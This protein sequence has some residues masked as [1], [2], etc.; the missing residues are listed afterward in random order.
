MKG[1]FNCVA[2]V[3]VFVVAGLLTVGEVQADTGYFRE[4]ADRKVT[5][6]SDACY[7]TCLIL[8]VADRYRDFSSQKN[9]LKEKGILPGRLSNARANTL[10]R[11]GVAAYMF[12]RTLDIR[13][14]AMLH[15]FR[16]SERYAL[17]E[18]VYKKLVSEGPEQQIVD[19]RELLSILMRASEYKDKQK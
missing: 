6:L 5:F 7:S 3:M 8:G 14:G 2:I 17:R 19:G 13:G 1:K 12:C 9:F 4:L 10:L 18:L 16:A 11:K 15:L